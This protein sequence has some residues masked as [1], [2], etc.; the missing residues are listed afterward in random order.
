MTARL[1]K[2]NN[3]QQACDIKRGQQ[4]GA[5]S[6][7]K[8]RHVVFVG[9]RQ[10]R[11]LAKKSAERRATHERE[12]ADQKRNKCDGKIAAQTAHFPNVLF[13]VKRDDDGAGREKEERFEKRMREKVIDRR[14]VR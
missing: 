1:A 8:D 13:V 9:E 3:Y 11:V 7:N 12:G 2:K 10:N 4:R 5:Q 14:V 6:D